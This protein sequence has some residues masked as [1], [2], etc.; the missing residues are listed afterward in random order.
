MKKHLV[1]LHGALGSAEQMRH[2][3]QGIE[4]IYKQVDYFEFSGHGNTARSQEFGVNQFTGELEHAL[5]NF[6]SAPDVFGYSM[7]GYVALNLAHKKS[8][9]MNSI[10]TLATKFNWTP[11]VASQEI[12]MLRPEVIEDKVPKFVEILKKRHGS[13]R[14]KDL[15]ADTAKMMVN[16]GDNPPLNPNTLNEIVVDVNLFVGSEDKMISVDET[17]WAHEHLKNSQL[18]LFDG[19]KH[20][21]EQFPASLMQDLLG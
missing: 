7:G 18:T 1:A 5:S 8:G 10:I 13:G 4:S 21:I 6:K 17:A 9:L 12:K 16:L 11:V 3:L 15:C 20:P 14:W 2:S 19:V